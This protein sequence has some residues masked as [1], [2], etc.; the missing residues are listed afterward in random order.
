M[1]KEVMDPPVSTPMEVSDL[2][3]L[4]SGD[5]KFEIAGAGGVR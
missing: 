4:P 1:L 3:D 2:P 5:L